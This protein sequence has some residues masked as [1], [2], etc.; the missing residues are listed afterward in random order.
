MA[1]STASSIVSVLKEQ[2]ADA[3][4]RG[5]YWEN[6]IAFAYNSEKMEGNP[7]TEEQTRSIFETRTVTGR[8]VHLDHIKE[9]ENHFKLFDYMLDTLDAPFDASLIKNYHRVL[10]AG[11]ADDLDDPDFAVGNWKLIPNGV[12]NIQTTPPAAVDAEITRLLAAYDSKEN[13]TY[14]HIVGFHVFFERIH[15]FQD[16]NGRVGRMLMFRECLSNDL[17]PFIVLDSE[18]QRYYRGLHV[19]SEQPDLLVGFAEDM[20]ELYLEA[21]TNLLPSHLLLPEL[22]RFRSPAPAIANMA[23]E[24]F[25][26]PELPSARSIHDDGSKDILDSRARSFEGQRAQ[27]DPLARVHDPLSTAPSSPTQNTRRHRR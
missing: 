24:F 22:E 1:N 21:Y 4:K 17:P 3:V 13:K 16:G 6:Q 26:E 20:A 5:F 14:R 18:K 7:L 27:A 2:R 8:A 15:P 19:F 11:T 25:A 10:K 23:E 9:T 12:D